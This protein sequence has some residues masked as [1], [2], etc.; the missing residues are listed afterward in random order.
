[1]AQLR[2]LIV[3]EKGQAPYKTLVPA[4]LFRGIASHPGSKV[5]TN[6][7][8]LEQLRARA[9]ETSIIHFGIYKGRGEKR[10]HVTP[11]LSIAR[12]GGVGE[13]VANSFSPS[14]TYV[15]VCGLIKQ[16]TK[17]LNVLCFVSC[18]LSRADRPRLKPMV[19]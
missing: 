13:G 4:I 9:R 8:P 14:Q 16:N 7:R 6:S 10:R 11:A 2:G 17:F 15:P 12:G 5:I 19:P 3:G 18:M 1:M